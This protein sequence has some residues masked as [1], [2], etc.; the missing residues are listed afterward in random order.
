MITIVKKNQEIQIKMTWAAY[1][2]VV[3][4]MNVALALKTD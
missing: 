4:S 3:L 2:K 1:N